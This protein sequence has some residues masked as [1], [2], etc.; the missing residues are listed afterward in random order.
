[1][2]RQLGAVALLL[3]SQAMAEETSRRYLVVGL[4]NNSSPNNFNAVNLLPK[5]RQRVLLPVR[6]PAHARPPLGA[7]LQPLQLRVARRPPYAR[8]QPLQLRGELLRGGERHPARGQKRPTSPTRKS[9]TRRVAW[10]SGRAISDKGVRQAGISWLF[11]RARSPPPP[12]ALRASGTAQPPRGARSRTCPQ[13]VGAA[14]PGRTRE[15]RE[16]RHGARRLRRG[17]GG[18]SARARLHGQVEARARGVERHAEVR[19]REQPRVVGRLEPRRAE[20]HGAERRRAHL[21]LEAA[22]ERAFAGDHHEEAGE[23]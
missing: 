22:A 3:C 6:P 2:Q 17:G 5:E 19:R 11:P 21:R 9:Q 12:R 4:T 15:R 23:P 13:P 18:A 14:H 8:Q 20:R 1:M 10:D 16:S 7:L